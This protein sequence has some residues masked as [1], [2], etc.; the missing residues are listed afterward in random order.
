MTRTTNTWCVDTRTTNHVCNSLQ[1]F[2]ETRR[3][4]DGKIYLW[5]GDTS[6]VA[7]KPVEEVSLHFGEHKVLVLKDYLYVPNI[8]RNLISVFCLACNEYSASFNKNSVSIINGV[9]EICS[10]M[11]IDN[12]YLIEPN[13]LLLLT[14]MNQT[15]R[16][17]NLPPLI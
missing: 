2:Q 8:R 16:E 6:R 10:G 12:L 1:E 9:D 7:A 13:T 15:I 11:L 4:V 14:H 3:L 17:R 5:L